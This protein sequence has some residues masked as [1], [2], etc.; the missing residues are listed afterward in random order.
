MA[1]TNQRPK[2]PEIL[3]TRKSK[4]GR[5]FSYACLTLVTGAAAL[6][7][8]PHVLSDPVH[9]EGEGVLKPA[10][11]PKST[12]AVE[13]PHPLPSLETARV[14]AKNDKY[15]KN[16][17]DFFNGS[18][19]TLKFEFE[20]E[21]WENLKKDN[22]RYA[23]S[24]MIELGKDGK[25]G[26]VYKGVGVKLKGSAGSFQGPDGKPGLTVSFNKFKDAERFHG[27]TKFHLNNGAQDGTF[28]QEAIAGE[29]G[30]K[31]GVPVSRCTH[32]LVSWDGREPVLYVFKEAFTKDFFP[33]FFK[34]PTGSLY[35][36]GFVKD[37]EENMEKDEGDP[38]DRADIKELIA[39]C[40]EGDGPKRWERLGKILDVDR[41]VSFL[42]MESVLCHWDGY[43]FNQNN[44]RVYFDGETKRAAFFL[45]GMDQTFGDANFPILRDPG[46]MVG[47]AVMSN[48]EW[49]ALYRDRVEEIYETVLKPIDW[50]A[51]V[52]AMGAKVRA[53]LAAQNEQMGKD[54]GQRIKEARERVEGR[55]AAVGKQ[56]SE[57]PKPFKFNAD[58]VA[59]LDAN[60]WRK[61][62][63]GA[64]LAEAQV[65]G[66]PVFHIRAEGE[67]SASW[68][69]SVTLIPGKYR[70]QARVRTAGVVSAPE[71]GAGLRISGG[72]RSDRSLASGDTP[73]SDLQFEFDAP[74]GDVVLVAE[75]RANKGEAWFD[76][77][78]FQLIRLK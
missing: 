52:E 74:G 50:G 76:R 34:G 21:E 9:A 8:V 5:F 49:K 43:N 56:L 37:I 41:F 57:I 71:R 73:W 48:P 77:D 31:A 15:R 7:V 10:P 67:S 32:A 63:G 2:Q 20:S 46:T 26:K 60:G 13:N 54:Y 45:H 11:A 25:P 39:A 24:Q 33:H 58:G 35:D 23:E 64:H 70:L 18:I 55:I 1:G 17:D 14:P 69:K 22:R 12:S 36:G 72:T 42:A 6:F 75:L 66:K 61:E 47:K 44:Y 4:I 65:D 53:A 16:I 3:G 19:P 38:K 59:K 78:S 27:M 29:M 28:L 30:R 51:R 68:R 40:Q 62:G